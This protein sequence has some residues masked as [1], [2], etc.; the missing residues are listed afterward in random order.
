MDYLETNKSTM[1]PSGW[2]VPALSDITILKNYINDSSNDGYE[3]S[4]GGLAWSPSW[5]GSDEYGFGMIPSGQIAWNQGINDWLFNSINVQAAFHV[6]E[7]NYVINRYNGDG[8]NNQLRASTI[9][10]EQNYQA[11]YSLRLV[12]N[13]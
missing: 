13:A 2:R 8:V 3:L 4:R 11:G 7:H 10:T 5:D 6:I 9:S 1:L 12:K